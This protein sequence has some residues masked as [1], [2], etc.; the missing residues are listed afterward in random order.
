MK[1]LVSFSLKRRFINGATILLNLLLFIGIGCAIHADKILEAINPSMLTQKVVYLKELDLRIIE[2]LLAI[3]E[4]PYKFIET[5]EKTETLIENEP[6][7]FV[8]EYNDT[9]QITSLYAVEAPQLGM[10]SELLNQ[11]HHILLFEEVLQSE[12]QINSMMEGVSVTNKIINQSIDLSG[13]KQTLIF[14]I[15]TSIYFTMLSFSTSVANE[16]I[17][18]KST[19][20]LELILTSVNAKSHF[21]SKMFVGWLAIIIQFICMSSSVLFWF[22]IRNGMDQGYGMIEFINKIGIFKCE[23]RTF[24]G[25]FKLINLQGDFVFRLGLSLCFLM[26]GILFIQM[27]LVVIS[28]FIAN[29][30]EAGNV[31]APFY[32]ILLAVYYFALSINSPYQLSEGIGF[33]LSFFPFFSMLIMPCRLMIQN[34]PLIELIVS[35]LI[36]SIA[37]YFVIQKGSN[38][39]QRGVLDYSSKG[40]IGVMKSVFKEPQEGIKHDKKKYKNLFRN[41]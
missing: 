32:L 33:Y 29:I 1:E 26:L 3:E 4:S 40:F 12:E 37:I 7:S 15:I 14:M 30:E 13:D 5:S 41:H 24:A 22:L 2:S 36:S 19:K 18:E 10:M 34:V 28:S 6:A 8:L 25:L 11:L 16:V 27:I 23:E 39:Y 17:Y 35:F 31:Q 9:Y 38:I 21:L 20:T